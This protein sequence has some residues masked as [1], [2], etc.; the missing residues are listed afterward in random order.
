MHAYIGTYIITLKL[1]NGFKVLHLQDCIH[2][3]YSQAE[4]D[5]N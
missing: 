3:D 4:D 1:K 2:K 5:P